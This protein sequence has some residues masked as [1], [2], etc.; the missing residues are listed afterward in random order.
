MK[1]KTD[2]TG[3]IAAYVAGEEAGRIP[4]NVAARAKLHILDALGAMV[5][6]TLLK[7]GRLIVDFVR[8]QGGGAEAMVVASTLRTNRVNA[9]LANGTLAHAD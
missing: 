3:I 7:P 6:G 2:L 8:K 4:E 1:G 9:A 5:S